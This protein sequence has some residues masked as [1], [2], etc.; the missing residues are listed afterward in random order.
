LDD[1]VSRLSAQDLAELCALADGTLPAE[2]RAEVEARVSTSPDLLE[3]VERQRRAVAATQ[4]LAEEPVP[5]SLLETVEGH[6]RALDVRRAGAWR[7]APRLA[8]V[9]GLAAVVAVLAAIVLSGG[10]GG[11]TVADAARLASQP[12][13]GPAPPPLGNN[14]TNLAVDVQG[15]AFPNLARSYGWHARGI[16]RSRVDGRSATVVFYA[17]DGRRIAYVIV[18]GASLPRPLR[19]QTTVRDGVRFQTLRTN[20]KLVVTWRRAGHTCV[21][22]GQAIRAQLLALASW[23]HGTQGH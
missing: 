19:A 1:V 16:R 23:P 18:A 9:G 5:A 3:L 21:L 12:P 20:G 22:T 13:N 10:P 17:K 6:R 14:S 11:P 7:L 15:V 4:A 2:R 8:L